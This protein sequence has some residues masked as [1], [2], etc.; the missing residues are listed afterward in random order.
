[1]LINS[2]GNNIICDANIFYPKNNDEIV[3]ILKDDSKINLLSI[4]KSRS[5]GDNG[6]NK[7]IIKLTEYE[8]KFILDEEKG[9][10]TCSSNFTLKEILSLIV[11]KGFFL[12]VTPGSK[13]VTI[14]GAVANDIHGKNHHKDGCF[15][16]YVEE[17]ELI[18]PNGKLVK[19]SKKNNQ[20]LF[21]STCGGVG[22]TGVIVGVKIKL[23]KINSSKMNVSVFKS[24]NIDDTISLIQKYNYKKYLIAWVDT[25]NTNN[26]GRSLVITGEHSNDNYLNY[27][28]KK[29]FKLPK[30]LGKFIGILFMNNFFIKIFNF[31]YFNM[32]KN[33]K[34]IKEEINKF[35]YPLDII[36]NWNLFYG[37]KG[38]TQ[39]QILIKNRNYTK[40]LKEIFQF[41]Q[42]NQIYS[43]LTTLK[44]FGEKNQNYLSFPEKGL[45]VTLDIKLSKN[46]DKIYEK[47]ENIL[48]EY[49]IK[50][51]LAKDS[52]MTKEYF[53]KTY[54]DLDKFLQFKRE[55]DPQNKLTSFQSKRLDI[56]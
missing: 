46:F 8:K 36:S 44:E 43:Y 1:M 29:S 14:G 53:K 32:N 38:F 47:L 9:S 40:I 16:D 7:N 54:N 28:N 27:Q 35:F 2:W 4:G 12:H 24:E 39:I 34:N 48:S 25:V 31:L 55:I 56:S 3:E 11:N 6:I 20:D 22:L 52:F 41:M 18:L 30:F 19:C 45:T 10:L 51:Y 15:S 26:F 13:K 33:K 5:Y 42:D 23:L 49:D 21:K 17:I 37:K 50:V